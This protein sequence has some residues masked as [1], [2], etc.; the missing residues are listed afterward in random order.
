MVQVNGEGFSVQ[1]SFLAEGLTVQGLG[2]SN[3]ELHFP[4]C[5]HVYLPFSFMESPLSR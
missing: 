4:I 1:V 2:L 5:I 3:P